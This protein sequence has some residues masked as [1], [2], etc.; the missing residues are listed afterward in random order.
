M[1]RKITFVDICNRLAARRCY[2]A[3]QT[4]KTIAASAKRPPRI[5]RRWIKDT[6]RNL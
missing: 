3:G 6:G 1:S 4:I 5:I 2:D